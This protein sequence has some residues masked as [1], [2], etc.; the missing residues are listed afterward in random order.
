MHF[1]YLQWEGLKKGIGIKFE[2]FRIE[3]LDFSTQFVLKIIFRPS[4]V[5]FHVVVTTEV[6]NIGINHN[7]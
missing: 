2:L 4:S 5:Q 6:S 3:N 7:A 1:V